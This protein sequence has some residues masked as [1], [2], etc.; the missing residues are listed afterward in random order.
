MS[1]SSSAAHE[2]LVVG[3]GASGLTIALLLAKTGRK[4]TLIEQQASIG[5]YLRRFTRKGLRFDTGFH[6]TAGF[7]DV[8][9]QILQVL[10]LER[11]VIP[12]PMHSALYLHESGRRLEP[13]A[14]GLSEL[15][16]YLADIF[17]DDAP[18]IRRYY[19]LEQQI[20]AETPLF[21]L[22][23][24]EQMLAPQL[25]SYDAIT[26]Q[27]YFAEQHF[28]SSELPAVLGIMAFCHGTPPQEIPL[29]QHCRISCGLNRHLS[30]VE[31]G[32]DAFLN[33]FHRELKRHGVT[34]RTN[35][36]IDK[37]LSF[38]ADQRCRE[39]LLS[40]GE[41]LATDT[42]FFAV[43]PECYLPLFPEALLTPSTRRR[44]GKYQDTCSFFAIY[45]RLDHEQPP[46]Q[47][48]LQYISSN[49]LNAVLGPG[50]NA[51]GTGMVTSSE[52]DA[53]GKKHTT[54]T[55]FRNM[56]LDEFKARCG[57][58]SLQQRHAQ[59]YLDTKQ[60]ITAEI[61]ADILRVYPQYAQALTVL[62]SATPLT[63]LRY[64]PPR[65]SAYGVRIK[66]SE[67]RLAGRLPVNNCFALGHHAIMP[68]ILGSILGAFLTFRLA[69]GEEQYN[70]VVANAR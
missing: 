59:Q 68:G 33:G 30:R 4:V 38:T 39:V 56:H 64:S 28:H 49:D 6:F 23:N 41:T 16:E 61:V 5:G 9:P 19:Q 32:G 24:T 63:F 14:T 35:T 48:L 20:V 11:D 22:H 36:T 7:D 58:T 8:M 55:A 21:N 18:A 52:R 57:I 53:Q 67:S 69:A 15:A 17:P 70:A 44:F 62:D 13:P 26:L 31:H 47:E 51:Y 12:S 2:A 25:S 3:S 66:M 46:K 50:A 27:E 42:I 45:G 37:M 60:Q 10:D 29:G 54:L 1:H 34:I 65:G 43:H 40:T